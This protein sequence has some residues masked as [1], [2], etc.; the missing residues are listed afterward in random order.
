M[1]LPLSFDK[2]SEFRKELEA[3]INKYSR[4][5]LSDTPDFILAEF[6][7][8]CLITF[9]A[10]TRERERWY[11]RY[12]QGLPGAPGEVPFPKTVH[13]PSQVIES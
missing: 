5:N 10:A 6:L 2:E 12:V 3:L 7:G 8:G 11:G 13:D 4:E 9:E 1:E